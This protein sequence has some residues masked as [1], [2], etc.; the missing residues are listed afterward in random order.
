VQDILE[1]EG[2]R[3]RLRAECI[4]FAQLG[5]DI[6][7]GV[8]CESGDREVVGSHVLLAVGRRP[9]TDDLGLDTAGI[10]TDKLGYI[11]VD[12]QLRTNVPGV[13][14]LGDC[15]GKGAFTH[16]SYNDFEI[17]AANLLD[18]DRR[19]VSDRLPAYALYVDPPLGRASMT[20]VEAR[21]F[22]KRILVGTRPMTNRNFALGCFLS[23]VAGI[24]IFTTIYLTP[25]FLGYVRGF[26][27][28]QTGTAIFSTGAA[29]LIGTPIYIL[30][31]RKIDLRWLLMGGLASFA[32]TMWSYSF[33]THDWGSDQLL[34]P[35]ILRGLPQVFAVAPFVNLGLGSL[36]PDRLK[37]ASGLVNMMRNLGGRGRHRRERRG[38]Q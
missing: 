28:W 26:S 33:I 24:G 17:V 14:A 34:L 36:P 6:A 5:A 32:L 12:D 31:A 16:T 11:M 7:V 13:W 27:A 23:F 38:R 22:G 10:E 37:F 4:S 35:Q 8:D 29:S 25:L 20:E 2:V 18:G 21:H 1:A 3:I 9:N 30:L 19:R 15:N